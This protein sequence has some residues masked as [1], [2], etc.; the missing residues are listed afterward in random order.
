MRSVVRLKLESYTNKEIAGQL[1][2]AEATVYRK[3]DRIRKGLGEGD[4][5]MSLDS[6]DRR[7]GDSLSAVARIDEACDAFESRLKKR[8]RPRLEEY[9]TAA[10]EKDRPAPSS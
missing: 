2:C 4:D 6:P 9:F 1:D 8:E 5:P 7:D 10:P 3:L